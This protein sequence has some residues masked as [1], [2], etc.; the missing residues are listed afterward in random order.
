MVLCAATLQIYWPESNGIRGRN[1]MESPAGMKWN[2]RPECSGICIQYNT[3]GKQGIH[4][5][6][7]HRFPLSI[8]KLIH[9][10]N[11]AKWFQD[12]ERHGIGLDMTAYF[13]PLPAGATAV[14][15]RRCTMM[16]IAL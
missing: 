3:G 5:F 14:A 7:R 4:F 10:L 16:S 1:E 8:T 9:K 12:D 6:G 11:R 15:P 13:L 2:H